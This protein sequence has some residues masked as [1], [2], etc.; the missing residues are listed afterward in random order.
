MSLVN[1]T[2]NPASPRYNAKATRAHTMAMDPAT[3]RWGADVPKDQRAHNEDKML[4]YTCHT[5]WTTSCGGC[6]LPIQANWKTERHKYE[7]G[8]TRNFATYNPQVARDDMFFLG[9]HGEIKGHKI[10]PVRSSSALVLS[11]TNINREKIYVQQPPISAAGYSSQAF[12]PHYPHTERKTET[13]EC[14]DC[15]LSNKNDNNAIMAQLLLLGTK[16]IDFIGYHAWVGEAGGIGAVQVTEWDEPQAV[17]GSY[18]HRYAYP[19]WYK[20]HQERG[21]KL[22]NAQEHRAGDAQCIQLR[23]EYVYVAEGSKGMRVYDAASVANKGFSEKLV[24]APF[25]PLGQDTHIASKNA[26]CVVLATTQPVDPARSQNELMQGANQEQV[27]SPIY[28]YAFITDAAEGLIV[29]DIATLSDRDSLNNYLKR[30]LTWNENDVLKGARHLAIAGNTFYVT[31]D[32]GVVVLDMADPLKPRHVATVPIADAHAAQVQF[33]YLFVTA[34][35]GL[36]VV[37]ITHPEAAREVAS[38]FVPLRDAHKLHV[39]RTYAYVADGVDGLAI[40]DVTNPEKPFVYQL[41]NAGGKISDA[42]DVVVAT[43]NASLYAYV[44]DGKNGLEVLQLTSPESQPK[45]Y[46]FSPDP[47]PQLIAWYPTKNP[48]QSLSRG[49]ERDRAVDESG[50]QIAIFGRIGSRPFHLDEM[51]RL[52][53]DKDGKPWYVDDAYHSAAARNTTD[54]GPSSAPTSAPAPGLD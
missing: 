44:A 47:K 6:H 41:F 39:A 29:T 23:G 43:T 42:R 11:S 4:C 9:V 32:A 30:S 52:Y 36:H 53:L 18:L 2:A 50:N 13:K 22:A 38:G 15:H 26:T 37:D 24:T 17:I 10:A 40:I 19:D 51:Q 16:F 27:M 1:E 5:S 35:D 31:A 33:R 25:S 48:A 34:K 3:Q 28:R 12:A 7:G 14:D 45:F 21:K 49:L 20:Q 8:A 54:R 46:G